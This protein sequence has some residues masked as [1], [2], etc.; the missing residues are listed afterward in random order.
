M[1]DSNVS[2]DHTPHHVIPAGSA[3]SSS[4]ESAERGRGRRLDWTAQKLVRTNQ[5]AGLEK[6]TGQLC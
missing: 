5:P 3:D 1:S 2:P 6:G 4:T